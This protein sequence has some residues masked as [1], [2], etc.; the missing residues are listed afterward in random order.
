MTILPLATALLATLATALLLIGHWVF[1][2][3]SVAPRRR[4]GLTGRFPRSF[5]AAKKDLM[6]LRWWSFRACRVTTGLIRLSPE[7]E[8]CPTLVQ[9]RSHQLLAVPNLV[10]AATNLC[11]IA[12]VLVS[13]TD[14]KIKIG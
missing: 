14:H 5:F 13:S 6:K 3:V 9:A 4:N 10:L 7:A 12:L 11:D 2:L 8:T 1:L